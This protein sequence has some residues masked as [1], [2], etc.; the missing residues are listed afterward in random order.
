MTTPHVVCLGDV[1]VD[2]LTRLAE[3]L[4]AGSDTPAAVT[5]TGGGSAA[6]TA[7][8]LAH[9]GLA[10]T[11]VGR[12][13]ADLP[14][15]AMRAALE[16]C[17]V[18]AALVVDGTA[19]TGTCVVLVDGA[20]ERS[21]IPSPGANARL[22]AEDVAAIEFDTRTHLHVSGYALFGAARFAALHAIQLAQQAGASVS[23]G[24]ASAAPLHSV[25]I[26]E[27]LSWTGG[28]TLF[29][30]GDEAA[31]LTGYDDPGAAA[32]ILGAA[33]EAAVVTAGATG[34]FWS[35]GVTQAFVPATP[36]A[37][38][39]DSTGAGDA[40]VAGYLAASLGGASPAA[41]LARGHDLG[42]QACLV[43]GGRPVSARTSDP[44][45]SG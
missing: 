19:P 4:H 6:N 5:W 25:G 10:A 28:A 3:P 40:F 31:V 2:V 33:A 36:V 39:L 34:A 8:W 13:G 24:A 20:G 35:D 27:F 12:V 30:N 14:G 37:A 1:M 16:E 26:D 44:T 32:D 23:I 45:P 38:P 43:L 17:G 41:A 7:C 15:Q 42:G 21:M 22:A 18:R 9:A 11:F 29:A